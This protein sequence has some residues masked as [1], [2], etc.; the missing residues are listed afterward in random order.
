MRAL[1]KG[2]GRPVTVL[3]WNFERNGAED[4]AKRT[5]AHELLVS[6]NPHLV[7]RQ[8]M[9]GAD[10]NGNTIMYQLEDVLGMRG[11]L[12]PQSSTAVFADPRVFRTLREWPNT[13]PMWVQPPTALTMGYVPAGTDATPLLV[14]SYHLNYASPTN[15]LA[16]V[17]W[18]ST[19]ADKKWTTPGGESVSAPALLGGDNNAYPAP[20]LDGD[21]ALPELAEINDRPHRLHRSYVGPEGSRQMDT[22]PDEA[23]RTAGMQDVAR[24]WATARGGDK[25]AVSRTVNACQTHGPDSRID[26]IYATTDLLDAVTGVD[27]IEVPLELSDHHIVRL[28]LDGD[29]LSDILH[30]RP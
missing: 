29:C 13:G 7:L 24:Y 12:G 1:I 4:A 26:R 10:A 3:S 11:W 8:E 21:P 17:E 16:E 22:R 25:T 5:Q 28:T 14:A 19:W 20:G 30:R 2:N 18:L 27:V 9:W 23:L 6:L 15:R